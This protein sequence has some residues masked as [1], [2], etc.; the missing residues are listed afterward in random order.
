MKIFK[1][2]E[3]EK[4]ADLNDPSTTELHRDI[5]KN[6]PFLKRI[7][8]DFYNEFKKSLLSNLEGK[9]IEIGSGG[10]FIKEIIPHVITSETF[11]AAGV[12][13]VVSALKLPFEKNSIGAFLLLDVLH[14]IPNPRSFLKEALRCL[15]KGGKIIMIEPAATLWGAFIWKLN[16][17]PFDKKSS[18][19]LETKGRL[20][21]ANGAMPWIIFVRDR[22][23]FESEYP[24]FKIVKVSFHT[25][26]RYILS[27]GLSF[28]QLLP[29]VLYDFIKIIEN[30]FSPLNRII[31]MYMTI[32]LEKICD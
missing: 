9:V 8:T 14:H 29:S 3:A 28:K 21:G 15:K 12:D 19:E 13:M 5:I 10:G 11:P 1:L 17:E 27:G 30:F 2:A 32:E 22:K 6:K 7:Y 16:N 4:I 20:T 31:G 18:W 26:F 24:G 25:P 23:V